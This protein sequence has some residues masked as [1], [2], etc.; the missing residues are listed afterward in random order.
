LGGSWS[1]GDTAVLSVSNN[2]LVRV[3]MR[4]G[5]TSTLLHGDIETLRPL[6]P[7]T[8]PGSDAVLF[9]DAR[10]QDATIEVLVPA[11]GEH[12]PLVRGGVY[13]RYIASGHILYVSR[14]TLFAVEF[15]RDTLT[16]RGTA[17]PILQD[18]GYSAA[19]GFAQF[20]A[21]TQALWFI[22][23]RAAMTPWSITADGQRLAFMALGMQVTGWICG[24]RT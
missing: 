9:T 4:N 11:T 8:L 21:S 3:D 24:R 20:D 13:G 6:W 17:H 23:A 5:Q 14:G 7:Q 16:T 15:D 12:R 19:F 18:V 22:D 10:G 2:T 1:S